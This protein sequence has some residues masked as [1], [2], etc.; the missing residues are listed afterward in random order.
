MQKI[1]PKL[2]G[3]RKKL[4]PVLEAILKTCVESMDEE[5]KTVKYKFETSAYKIKRMQK[6]LL[7]NGFTSFA[8]A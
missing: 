2:H 8:E 6:R 5:A 4:G 7:E 3:S 1:L